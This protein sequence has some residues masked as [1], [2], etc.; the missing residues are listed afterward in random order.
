MFYLPEISGCGYD[1]MMS[2]VSVFKMMLIVCAK[3]LQKSVRYV[4]V[5]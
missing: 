4:A 5:G 2:A 3:V 1:G